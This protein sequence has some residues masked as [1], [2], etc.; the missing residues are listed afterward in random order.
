VLI[1]LDAT[2]EEF[3]RAELTAEAA[4]ARLDAGVSE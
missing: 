3:R 2:P 4:L 1:G